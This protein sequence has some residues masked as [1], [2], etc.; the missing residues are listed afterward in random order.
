M[1]NGLRTSYSDVSDDPVQGTNPELL[2]PYWDTAPK[3][4]V[5]FLKIS[6]N[7]YCWIRWYRPDGNTVLGGGLR[8]LITSSY[9]YYL[10]SRW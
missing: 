10:L 5:C 1:E 4:M 7:S 8:A 3:I 6:V 9:Y 2:N